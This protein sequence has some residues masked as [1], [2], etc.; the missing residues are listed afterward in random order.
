MSQVKYMEL[1]SNYRN[2]NMFPSPAS[3]EVGISQTGMKTNTYALDPVTQMYPESMF[4]ISDFDTNLE[5]EVT[6]VPY[7]AGTA[8]L[9]NSSAGSE[10]VVEADGS[11]I[12]VRVDGYYNGA[13]I[14]ITGDITENGNTDTYLYRRRILQWTVLN[15]TKFK[16]TI[17]G[18]IPDNIFEGTGLVALKCIISRPTDTSDTTS[19]FVFLPAS[20]AVDNYYNKYVIWNQTRGYS[21]PIVSFDRVTH[22]AKLGDLGALTLGDN[23]VLSIRKVSPVKIGVLQ[24]SSIPD[25][26][27][28][29]I[30]QEVSDQLVNS[31]IRLYK[32]ADQLP[33]VSASG[34]VNPNANII[35]KIVRVSK[36]VSPSYSI[37]LDAPIPSGVPSD[38]NYEILDF[39]IDNYSP[40]IY[41]GS[42]TSQSQPVAHEI[43]LNSLILPNVPLKNGGR[44]AYYPYVYVELENVSSSGSSSKNIIYSNN[45]NIQKAIFKVPITDLNHPSVSPFVKLTGNGMKQT[46]TF[47]QNDSMRVSVR[48]PNGSEFLSIKSDTSY[49]AEP[50]PFLQISFCFGME[51]I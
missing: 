44:I 16:V 42:L 6:D 18:T 35:R 50:N 29:N 2:R 30:S 47:K 13:V 4:R 1:N 49:G 11:S 15:N 41:T 5:L 20:V 34:N 17:E 40:F 27:S 28:Y 23:D 51:R 24:A 38:Y 21:I 19:P 43:T 48:L 33:I 32:T 45:P 12:P 10:F 7:A 39:S 3:F 25:P 26:N 22:L 8:S 37:I 46:M 14:F 9:G 36:A 31:F